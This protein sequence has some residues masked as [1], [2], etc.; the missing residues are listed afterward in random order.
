M[1]PF[2]DFKAKGPIGS[3]CKYD[4]HMCT[5]PHGEHMDLNCHIGHPMAF[6]IYTLLLWVM[7]MYL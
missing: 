4:D 5:T 1:A 3:L 2:M 6:K 7:R